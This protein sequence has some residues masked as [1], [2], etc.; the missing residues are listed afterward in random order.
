MSQPPEILLDD[1]ALKII[2]AR[3][4]DPFGYLGT[5]L[6]DDGSVKFRTF[7]SRATSVKVS[8]PESDEIIPTVRIHEAG[9]YEATLPNDS[10]K[11]PYE[12]IIESENGDVT[13]TVDPYSFGLL[14]GD[15]DMHYFCEGKHWRLYDILGSHLR[16]IDGVSGIL[17]AVWAPNAQR[18]SVVGDFNNWDGRANP[19]RCRL[20]SGI[21]EIFVPGVG[22]NAHYKFEVRGAHGGI[23]TKS[24]PFAF[25]SQNGIQ[26]ASLTWDY[27]RYQW[28]DGEWMMR[29]AMQNPYHEAVSIYEVH[30]GSWRH[31]EGG[32]WL[33]YLELAEQLIPYVKDLGFT[34]IELMPVSEFPFDGSWGY[35]VG[36][37]FAPTSRYGNP[38]DFREFVDLCHEA[39][40]GV[41]V[42]WVPA[43]FPKDA[44]GL[45]RFDGTALYEHADPR[46]GEHMDWGTLIFNFGRNEVRNFL[47]S[48]AL[49]W[50]EQYHIDGIRVDAV[51]S[52]LYLDYSREHGQ[53]VPNAN[54][55]RENLDAIY[56]MKELNQQCYAQHPG[57]MMI[58]EESTSWPGV[59][60]SVATGGL[61][62]GFKWNMGWMNDS[63]RYISK[64][65]I[66]RKYHHGQATFSMLYAY[67]ENFMLVLSHDEVVHGKGSM[68]EKMP[69]DRWQK[70]ANLR[71]F[72][73]WMWMH[74]GKKLLFMGI[75]I[76]QWREW[77]HE[78]QL[79][80]EVL[81]GEE[82]RNLQLLIGDLNRLYTGKPALHARDHDSSGFFWLDANDAEGSVFA[83]LRSAP[84]GSKCYAVVN[85]TPVLRTGYRLGVAE[86]G[87][88]KELLNT[89]SAIYSG[90]NAGNGE[91]LV[92]Q[93][94]PWQ[95]QPWSVVVTLPPLA[96]IVL[97]RA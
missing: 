19:M 43:H 28:G 38:D 3:H 1:D 56:F 40:I 51:A 90:S 14:L 7:Q 11:K 62:F 96:T 95:G 93:A 66:H 45:A 91:G 12:L 69:G 57:V 2:E 4:H 54:G 6:Q 73:A 31:K 85:A 39:N 72:L 29:R 78:R 74:P 8:L 76:G 82:H 60:R 55:G 16:T 41:I 53:W 35:Q 48:N 24:D 59:S 33:T 79:D 30:L 97:E 70:F 20:E 32:R 9:L 92:A 81:F 87:L 65:P 63:L 22:L 13:H 21:W 75:E 89:D 58:A 61:G 42:D 94:L 5:H 17:F 10:W 88:Y 50:L 25:F 77:S 47:V 37:Y 83:F 68:L 64:E 67:D 18:V 52:M 80:W 49:F 26:T 15:Q 84:D 27:N 23:V 86:G 36:G 71:M 46:Q 34:H 44:H